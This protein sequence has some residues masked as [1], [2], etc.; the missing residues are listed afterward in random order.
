MKRT[1]IRFDRS[2]INPK[3]DS[4]RYLE[5]SMD[6]PGPERR[7]KR[8]R[9]PMDLALVI[10]RSG[11]MRGEPLAAAREA[12][13]GVAQQL[14]AKDTLSVV[15][16]DDCVDTLFE[17]L[18]MTKAGKTRAD[19]LLAGIHSGGMTCLSDGWLQGAETVAGLGEGEDGRR[20]QVILL[21][22]GHAN[23]GILDPRE[24]AE[25][26]AALRERGVYTTCV[27]IGDG[28]SPEQLSV[29]SE[30]GGGLLHRAERPQ[31]I[32]EVLM[33]ELDE[34]MNTYAED[35]KVDVFLPAHGI[36][37]EC[38]GEL[39]T[40]RTESGVRCHLGSIIEGRQRHLILRL[41]CPR[42]EPQS[43]LDFK[44][45]IVFKR[46]GGSEE[47]IELDP[48]SLEFSGSR[49][50]LRKQKRD[51]EL[52]LRVAELWQS[53]VVRKASG[54]NRDGEYREASRMVRTQ[55]AFFSRYCY[56]IPGT[57]KLI[58]E[59]E[60]LQDRVRGELSE[61]GRKEMHNYA[62]LRR[63]SKPEHRVHYSPDLDSFMN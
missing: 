57:S 7:S 5:V 24:L 20:S 16:F 37:V 48:A 26:S 22:D 54:M 25:H 27:G 34:L 28:Y 15:V 1:A 18:A 30:N 36:L 3:G 39:P 53:D 40:S 58:S 8:K 19:A 46:P 21:S 56:G 49:E 47:V 13:R 41:T 61:R 43:S 35:I 44:A 60:L 14:R 55:L 17:G 38:V 31:E 52:S 6:S 10:D 59:L 50:A 62:E 2:L 9:A 33:G 63:Y 32:I 42:G 51:K 23:Q 45:R 29:L 4:V 12:A 11:S